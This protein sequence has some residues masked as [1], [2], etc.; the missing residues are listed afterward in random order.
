MLQRNTHVWTLEVRQH[1]ELDVGR[2]FVVV[3]LVLAR[4]VGNETI[5]VAELLMTV[6]AVEVPRR[7]SIVSL[8]VVLAS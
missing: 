2:G 8:L 3:E 1:D 5:N 7:C 6:L 4:A